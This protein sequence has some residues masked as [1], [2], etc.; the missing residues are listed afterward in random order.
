MTQAFQKEPVILAYLFTAIKT[1]LEVDHAA[2][3]HMITVNCDKNDMTILC[4][5]LIMILIEPLMT[6]LWICEMVE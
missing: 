1:E 5:F 3:E 6:C 2:K 4:Y